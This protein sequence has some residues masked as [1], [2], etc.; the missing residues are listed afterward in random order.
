LYLTA[1]LYAFFVVL[2]VKG[3]FDWRRTA[4]ATV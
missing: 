4:H 2:C 3:L 1:G